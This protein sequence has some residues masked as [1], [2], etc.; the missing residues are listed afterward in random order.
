MVARALTISALPAAE[1]AA[2]AGHVVALAHGGEF[3]A[4]FFGAVA[5]RK[6]G[7]L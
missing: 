2:P 6:L 1:A 5:A 3:D 4:D 7:A